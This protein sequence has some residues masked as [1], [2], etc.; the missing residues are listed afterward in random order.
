MNNMPLNSLR[1]FAMVFETGGVRPAARRLL[2]S[3]S[4]ISRHLR[5]LQAW[6][7][8]PLLK[9]ETNGRRL[10]FTVQGI[11]LG[12]VALENLDGIG[13]T[14]Q[15]LREVR[16]GNSV[17]IS[18]PASV[19]VRW[20]LPR[21][22]DLQHALPFV[23]IS[24]V[25]EQIIQDPTGQ[26][27]DISIRMGQGPWPGVESTALMDDALYP[28]IHPDLLRK[29]SSAAQSG[30]LSKLPL[31]HDR[32]PMASWEAWFKAYPEERIDLRKG[33]RFTSSDLVL[34][35]ATQHL[36]IAL[37]RD[38]LVADDLASG[39][40]VRPFGAKAII[41]KNA[42]WIVKP[43]GAA[44]RRVVDQV[45]DWLLSSARTQP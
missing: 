39:A 8:V 44:K 36:G 12:K 11:T 29:I 22:P 16:Q 41:L 23:E 19:A 38:R 31:L 27:V 6:L 9:S 15:T 33:A 18:T 45:T 17:V 32:D 28:V 1:A 37:A 43:Q 21:L 3:H 35:A 24:V 26:N 42:Y 20:L 4:S 13:R 34:R 7:G 25:T 14:I 5:D 10:V 40:L 2:V 30:L